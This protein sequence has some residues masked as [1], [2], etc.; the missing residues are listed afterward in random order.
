MARIMSLAEAVA[1]NVRDG[2]TVAMEGFTHLIPYAAGHE[3]IRQ[4]RKNLFLVRM[5]PDILYDQLIG[6]GAARGMKFSWGG[7]PGVGSLH[8]FRD[9]VENQWPRPLEIE[10]HSHAAMAN[11]Y[12]AGAANLPFATLRGYIGADLPK[13]NPNI[14]SVTCPFTG[15]VLAAVPAIRP[16]VTIIHAQRADRKGNVLIEGIVG[17]Q[18]EAV[19]AAK[20][21]IV[22]VEEI[23]E[24][25]S[26]PSP[27]SVVL[28]GWAVTAVVHVP[29]GAFPSYAHG[30]YPRSN[31]F[32]IR[33]DEIA[34]DRETFAAW[35][36]D[37]VLDAKP[38][39]YARYAAKTAKVA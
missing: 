15:E 32:Y 29:G 6:V 39:D 36:K 23:V 14:K 10:E 26:P 34:R 22:T 9:A 21:S 33:W 17:V 7:N 18:K 4:G 16:D 37:N 31:A 2:D 28:P 12:E 20:R 19:L 38:E 35:I 8:R 30:Y 3:V 13:V 24:E 25:L 27:N 11:A 1:E 5:T